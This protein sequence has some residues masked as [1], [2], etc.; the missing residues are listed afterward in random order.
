LGLVGTKGF[1]GWHVREDPG[2]R[3]W[4]L[5]GNEA[6]S[7]YG[8]LIHRGPAGIYAY[9]IGC[10]ENRRTT[11]FRRKGDAET[12]WIAVMKVFAAARFSE[13]G[14][15]TPPGH[16]PPRPRGRIP[17][18]ARIALDRQPCGSGSLAQLSSAF[19]VSSSSN[20][21]LNL[22]RLPIWRIQRPRSRR[23]RLEIGA[24]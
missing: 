16:R 12:E 13:I 3:F 10:A 14:D 19:S 4:L 2:R 8:Y 20:G 17:G 18:S 7:R 23:S 21:S 15:Q 22:R 11:H 5:E 6:N 9:D 1:P 24:S